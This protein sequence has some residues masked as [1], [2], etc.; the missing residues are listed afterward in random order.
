MLWKSKEKGI[1]IRFFSYFT[2]GIPFNRENLP[3]PIQI[4]LSKK[5]YIFCCIFFAFLEST[6]N[7]Q[8]SEKK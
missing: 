4:K 2:W 8:C 3:L 6:L 5:P 7:F 1:I